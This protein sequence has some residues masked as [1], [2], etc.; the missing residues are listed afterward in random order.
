MS[1]VPGQ[2]T[3]PKLTRGSCLC[4]TVHWELRAEIPDATIC[5]CSICRR[6]G[7]IWA[8]DFDGYGIVVKDPH[9]N[10]VSYT[11]GSKVRSFNFCKT[12]G[13]LVSWRYLTAG[14]DGKVRIAV[15]LR[16]A[17]PSEVEHLLVIRCDGLNGMK[18]LPSDGRT[19]KDFWF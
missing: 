13:N 3:A 18:D 16:L 12:C 15:N 2:S 11:H 8:Y 10:L 19:V 9:D 4:G 5:N 6:Y 14:D 7:V 1:E 17:D